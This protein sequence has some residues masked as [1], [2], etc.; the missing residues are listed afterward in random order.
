[1]VLIESK[2]RLNCSAQSLT[3]RHTSK[4]FVEKNLHAGEEKSS[5]NLFY[6]KEKRPLFFAF[7]GGAILISH[8]N[9]SFV[10]ENN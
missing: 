6:K 8:T 4:V 10:K 3:L 1:M 5:T 9:D 2:W 7:S